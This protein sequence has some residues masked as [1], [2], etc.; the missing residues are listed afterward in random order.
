M[1][2]LIRP[3]LEAGQFLNA[4]QAI[5]TH[6]D[7]LTSPSTEQLAEAAY[8]CCQANDFIRA[9]KLYQRCC[10][11]TPAHP[12][13]HYNLATTLRI[14]GDISAA[15]TALDCHL[16]KQPQD[17]EAHW[18]RANLRKQHAEGKLVDILTSLTAETHPPKQRVHACYALGK[19]YEDGGDND[20]CF[21][22]YKAGADLRRRYLNYDVAND[23]TIMAA[24]ASTFSS[25]WFDRGQA[26]R[27]QYSGKGHIFIVG[28]PRSGTTLVENLLG[29]H[30]GVAMGGELNAFASSM[31]AEVNKV[32]RPESIQQAIEQAASCDFATIGQRYADAVKDYRQGNRVLTDKLPLNF[33]Y[34]G[35]IHQALPQA[36]LIHITRH[37]MDTVWSVYKHLFTHAYPFSYQLEEIAE[38][39]I[40]YSQLMSHWKQ[41]LGDRLLEVSYESLVNAPLK[42]MQRITDYCDIPFENDCFHFYQRNTTVTT[43]SA[44]QVRQPVNT[45]SI[46]QW[47][48][49][50]SQL[51]GVKNM[52]Q[53]TGL[54]EG[55]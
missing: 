46:G 53:N 54:L 6:L 23:K 52:L 7:S 51:T 21:N 44:V 31:M 27:R 48:R 36:K 41:L 15:E 14:T 16:S 32:A 11:Q 24:I 13:Y 33:L 3:Q 19:L 26:A 43:G 34:L 39:Y 20:A 47:Q 37:P 1:E 4:Q 28:M 42:Q 40:A 25:Q 38:Y 9:A 5:Q 29:A 45:R 35:L 17:A 50:A 22:A 30:T 10:T 12:T 18:L 55:S 2:Q 49:F 8:W